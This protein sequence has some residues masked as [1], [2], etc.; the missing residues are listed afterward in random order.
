MLGAIYGSAP[1]MPDGAPKAF[2]REG[3]AN[4]VG[5]IVNVYL[6]TLG[7]APLIVSLVGAA[8]GVIISLVRQ[9]ARHSR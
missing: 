7:I 4:A 3:G 2:G 1:F 6:L 9:T 5:L 8:L